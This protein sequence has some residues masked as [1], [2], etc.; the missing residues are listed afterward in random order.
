M[1]TNRFEYI[2]SIAFSDAGCVR[3]NNEDAYCCLQ[4]D[5]CFFVADGMG[6]GD[7]GEIASQLV[8]E[9]I[10]NKISKSCSDLPGNRKYIIQQALHHVN[11][12]IQQY[13]REHGY[14]QMG[15]TIALL[16]LDSWDARQALICHVGDSRIYRLR[17]HKLMQLTSDHT[18]GAE[19]APQTK[20]KSFVNHQ[21]SA[22]SHVLTRAIGTAPNIIPEWKA[23]DVCPEDLFLICSDG[24]TT[25]ISD[26]QLSRLLDSAENLDRIS[27]HL[28]SAISQAGAHDNY[29]FIL[30]KVCS[31][32]PEIVSHSQA[33][34][35]ENNYLLKIA[36]ERIDHVQ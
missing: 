20:I 36:E 23:V 27:D 35:E 13:S 10:G 29:T 25:M 33:D 11:D 2:K 31:P 14:H 18:I 26:T 1:N 12:K 21:T 24:V 32:L 19:L 8:A 28:A 30:C 3:T 22:I 17:N 4:E 16:L 15:A 7:A 6:G 5:G 9:Y 34:I